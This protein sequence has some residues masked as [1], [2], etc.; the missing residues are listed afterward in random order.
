MLKFHATIAL[1]NDGFYHVPGLPL[2]HTLSHFIT[3]T[4][5]QIGCCSYKQQ[6][7]CKNNLCHSKSLF[8]CLPIP[9]LIWFDFIL[10]LKLFVHMHKVMN[11]NMWKYLKI[12]HVVTFSYVLFIDSIITL[13]NQSHKHSNHKKYERCNLIPC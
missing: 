1:I 4:K 3:Q 7:A 8:Y 10:L 2:N 9:L 11:I 13:K 5:G 12:S 6:R